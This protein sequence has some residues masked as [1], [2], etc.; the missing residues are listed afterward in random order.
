MS[1]VEVSGVSKRYDDLWAVK[2][3]SFTA[4]AGSFTSLLGPSGCGK[5]T[6][7]RLIAGFAA[8]DEG[9]VRIGGKPVDDLPPWRRN[10]GVVFQNYALFPFM[11]V[12]DNVAFGLRRRKVSRSETASRVAEAIDLVGLPDLAQR[13]PRQLSGGQQ[14]RVALA[15]ALVV[16]PDVLLLDEPLS[17]LDAKLRAEMR[18]E[19]KRIQRE[20]GVTSI[21]VTHD[22]EEALTLSDQIVVMNLGT[23]AGAAPPKAIWEQPESAYVADFLGVENLFPGTVGDGAA[24]DGTVAVSVDDGAAV[25]H[26]AADRPPDGT[27]DRAVVLGIRSEEIAVRRSDGADNASDGPNA[28]DGTV[29]EF[30][31]IG[32]AVVYQV[33][34]PGLPAPLIATAQEEFPVGA[35]VRLH[36]PPG[37]IKLLRPDAPAEGP[38]D[39]Q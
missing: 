32:S 21:F 39:R 16:R 10:L 30:T 26:V 23:V 18:F 15:R 2:R 20:T 25:L 3:V 31:Y 37:A 11:T 8:L 5:T 35:R 38:E 1:D 36:L 7:L 29:R 27:P 6:T 14:Q 9:E 4:P 33:D 22:Q 19:L 17:N 13:Y 34:C 12:F 24:D 28:L